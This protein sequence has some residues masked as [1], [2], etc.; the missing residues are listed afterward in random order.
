[1]YLEYLIEVMNKL[2]TEAKKSGVAGTR[3][4]TYK[5]NWKK[6]FATRISNRLMEMKRQQQEEGRPELNQPA[7]VVADKNA[8]EN[9]AS[10]AFLDEN[11]PN[12]RTTRRNRTCG[13]GI[14][15]RQRKSRVNWSKQTD[16]RISTNSSFIW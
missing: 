11:Y 9:K 1:M 2:A 3:S 16:K 13:V 6:G 4:T 14:C 5:T 15:G 7:L 10:L 12:R 8:I